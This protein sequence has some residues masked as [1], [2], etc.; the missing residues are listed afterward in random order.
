MD[1]STGSRLGVALGVGTPGRVSFFVLQTILGVLVFFWVSRRVP[2]RSER[3]LQARVWVRAVVTLL[4]GLAGLA[5][6][7]LWA[8]W[9]KGT[10]L[11]LIASW[12]LPVVAA[13][14]VLGGHFFLRYR[15]MIGLTVLPLSLYLWAADTWAIRAGIWHITEATSLGWHLP[16]GL[17]VEEALFFSLT[18]LMV[19]Q[20]ALLVYTW[21]PGKAFP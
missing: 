2:F 16:G 10:Y 19:V 20:G 4:G 14:W 1:L 17:P 6:Y 13:Q 9:E 11:C 3:L 8:G 18:S 12:A 7:G 15:R 5:G 21:H